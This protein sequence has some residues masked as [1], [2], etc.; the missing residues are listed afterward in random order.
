MPIRIS[1]TR[2]PKGHEVVIMRYS[3][4][5]TVEDC[6]LGQKALGLRTSDDPLCPPRSMLSLTVMEEGAVQPAE[7]RAFWK[8]TSKKN[9]AVPGSAAAIVIGN[10]LTRMAT[11][12]I[13]RLFPQDYRMRVFASETEALFWLEVNAPNPLQTRTEVPQTE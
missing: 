2:T 9:P 6:K 5:I 4:M 10:S 1:A 7:V 13:F 12:L 3:G 11:N 8:E